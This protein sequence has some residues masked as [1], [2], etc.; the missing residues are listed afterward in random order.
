MLFR[1]AV[2]GLPAILLPYPQAAG[3][4]QW[5]N[6]KVFERVGAARLAEP[7]TQL[8]VELQNLLAD[9]RA[10]A[11]MAQAARTL[12]VTDAAERI[13]DLVETHVN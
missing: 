7:V 9:A 12:A 6:A 3:N 2:F 8:S 1:S 5:H 13:A 4:H 10:R 11:G